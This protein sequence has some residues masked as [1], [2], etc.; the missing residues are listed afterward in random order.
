[1]VTRYIP[2]VVGA[3][4]VTA[5]S[6]LSA[7]TFPAKPVRLMVGYPPGGGMDGI[8]RVV[9]AKASEQVGQQLLVDNRPG[10]SGTL[11]AD[12]VARAAP[13]GYTLYVAETGVLIAP[14]LYAKLSFDPQKSFTPVAAL[15]S[16]PLAIVVNPSVNARTPAELIDLIKANPDRLSYGSPGIG[17]LQHLAMAIFLKRIG[18]EVVHVPYRGA[19]PMMPDLM[20]GQ[21]PIAVISATPALAQSRA[22]KLRAIALTSASRLANAPEWPTLAETFA[23]F[24]AAP[25]VFILAPVGTPEPIVARLTEI[26]RAAL[27]APEVIENLTKQGATTSYANAATLG[28]DIRAESTKWIAAAREAGLK[29]E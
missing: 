18:G 13:D 11:A 7:Q 4:L 26:F 3:L 1:M 8:A 28:T 10:A 29:P 16:L 27:A 19:A 20:S 12:A 24:D 2:F 23:G 5:V 21:I 14:A 15:A 25:R 17:S 6:S 22:G 9:A